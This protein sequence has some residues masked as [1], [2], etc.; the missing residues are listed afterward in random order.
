MTLYLPEFVLRDVASH[1][2]LMNAVHEWIT[3]NKEHPN[4]NIANESFDV[5]T[6]LRGSA[7]QCF[8]FTSNYAKEE[9]ETKRTMSIE[10]ECC[11]NC[12]LNIKVTRKKMV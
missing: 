12:R 3:L 8:D 7:Q 2:E 1:E 11:G 10:L 5:V 4:F 9:D 6:Y